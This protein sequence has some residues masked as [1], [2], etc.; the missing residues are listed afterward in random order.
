MAIEV[1]SGARI[2]GRELSGLRA[3]KDLAGVRRRILIYGGSREMKTGDSIE[4][5]PAGI[6]AQMLAADG[7][8]P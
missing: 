3:I 7:L 2:S 5:W 8:W 6:F 4:L 1:K